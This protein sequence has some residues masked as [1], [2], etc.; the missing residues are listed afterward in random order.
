MTGWQERVAGYGFCV[1][2]LALKIF[3]VMPLRP[4]V[5]HGHN[6]TALSAVAK[7]AHILLQAPMRCSI[8][9]REMSI[10]KGWACTFLPFALGRYPRS[11]GHKTNRRQNFR[12]TLLQRILY[13]QYRLTI[14]IV[15][16]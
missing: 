2:S 11:V 4:F 15:N 5:P 12:M 1:G 16:R 3:D 13:I 6:G 14:F 9:C 8:A 10:F 7:P